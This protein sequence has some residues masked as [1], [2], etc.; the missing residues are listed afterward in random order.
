VLPESVEGL[1]SQGGGE[2]RILKIAYFLDSHIG[3]MTGNVFICEGGAVMY[4]ALSKAK[5]QMSYV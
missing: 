5:K 3:N 4:V 1:P 2:G